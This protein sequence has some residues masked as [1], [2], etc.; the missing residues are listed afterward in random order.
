MNTY[1][2]EVNVNTTKVGKDKVTNGVCTLYGLAVIVK[3]RKEP[4][5]FGSDQLA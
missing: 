4:G 3:G 5:V 2:I 1:I